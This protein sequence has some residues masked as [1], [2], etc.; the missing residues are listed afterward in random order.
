M[1]TSAS[2]VGSL[3]SFSGNYFDGLSNYSQD[4]NNTISREVQIASLPIQLL[5][6]NLNGLT[7]QSSELQNLNSDFSSVQSA[8]ST[9]AA[10]ASNVLSAS[11]S[12]PSVAG[13]SIASNATVGTYSLEV[14]NLGSYSN[15]MSVGTLPAVTDPSSQNISTSN[16]FTLTLNGTT[17]LPPIQPAGNNL[18]AL[19]QAINNA[20]QGVQATVVN[21]GSNSSPSYKLSLQSADFGN[22]SMQ[23]ND[24]SS[25]LLA[26]TGSPGQ[27]VQYVVNGQPVTGDSR[28][29]TLAPGLTVNLTGTNVGSPTTVSVA[30]DTSGISSA[31]Q[32]FVSTYNTAMAELGTNR[33]QNT[34]ALGGQSIVYDLANALQGVANYAGGGSQISSLAAVG[35]SFDDTTGQLS[36]DPT[37]FNSITS[38]QTNALATFLGSATGGGFLESATN[39]LTS[40]EDPTTG[41]LSADIST[42]QKSITNTNLQI[43]NQQNQVNLLQASLTTQMSAADAMIY[44]LQQQ[45]TYFQQMFTAQ[46]AAENAGMA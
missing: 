36:F 5:Q 22:V 28:A 26:S 14:D 25:D 44:S 2:P 3:G 43:T 18:D 33:G 16:S 40:V 34:G 10:A 45:N 46:T 7:S 41:I 27:P 29:I 17:M 6:N 35:V 23:L 21:V 24:G 12:A 38:G 9:L 32:N 31:L 8:I 37:T 13:V 30:P 11:V 4:L 19:A 1:S 39:A 15:A 42:T 20:A